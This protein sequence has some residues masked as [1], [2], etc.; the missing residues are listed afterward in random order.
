[1]RQLLFVLLQ[2]SHVVHWHDGEELSARLSFQT[3]NYDSSGSR[4][5]PYLTHQHPTANP[6]LDGGPH[7][8]VA[9]LSL[10]AFAQD[11]GPKAPSARRAERERRA[12]PKLRS[13]KARSRKGERS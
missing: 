10:E 5:N 12:Q 13:R 4:G 2:V 8:R 3:A 7:I 1:M 11:P 9:D 6:K